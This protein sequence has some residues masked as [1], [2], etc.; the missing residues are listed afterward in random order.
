MPLASCIKHIDGF[1]GSFVIFDETAWVISLSAF[2]IPRRCRDEYWPIRFPLNW[3]SFSHI[4]HLNRLCM[5]IVKLV[6]IF[7]N[8][9]NSQNGLWLLRSCW[10]MVMLWFSAEKGE[11]SKEKSTQRFSRISVRNSFCLCFG[12]TLR[13]LI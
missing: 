1:Y 5:L 2:N 13:P 10:K 11:G 8:K 6:E 7:G 12:D 3:P 4:F 9:G